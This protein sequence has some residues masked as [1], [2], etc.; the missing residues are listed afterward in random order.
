MHQEFVA[1]IEEAEELAARCTN[2]KDRVGWLK[3]ADNCRKQLD[4]LE[5]QAEKAS[6]EMAAAKPARP[7]R[8]A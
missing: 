5:R 7:R 2:E 8:A 6:S 3:I 1:R 4:R